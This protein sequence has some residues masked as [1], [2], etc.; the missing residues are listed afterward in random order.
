MQV[1]TRLMIILVLLGSLAYG[2]YAF[3]KYVLSSHLLNQS[4]VN[5][6]G[7]ETR[8]STRAAEAVTRQTE[9]NGTTPRVE[10]KVLPAQDD[11]VGPAPP[12]RTSLRKATNRPRDDEAKADADAERTIN[13]EASRTDALL[14]NSENSRARSNSDDGNTPTRRSTQDSSR[15]TDRSTERSSD[16]SSGTSRNNDDNSTER[17]RDKPKRED[18]AVIG[19]PIEGGG[20]YRSGGSS[21]SDKPRRRRRRPKAST[22]GSPAATSPEPAPEAATSSPVP[23]PESRPSRSTVITDSPVPRAESGGSPIPRP[24]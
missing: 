1:L 8:R 18:N 11:G 2:S 9:Y 7:S 23:R 15:S 16:R 22:E 10:V 17:D 3:G 24:E 21:S 5:D 14:N 20:V 12:S 13:E 6:G 4:P 19:S